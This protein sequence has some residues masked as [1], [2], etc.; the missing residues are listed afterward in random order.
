MRD[1]PTSPIPYADFIVQY[2]MQSVSQKNPDKRAVA[3]TE[4]ALDGDRWFWAD[5]NAKIL[6]FMSLPEVWKKYP[7]EIRKIFDFVDSLCEGPYIFRRTGHPRIEQVSR[8]GGKSHFLHTFL[9]VQSDLAAG[10][11]NVGMR[12]HDGRTAR[13]VIL[14]GNYVRFVYDD[15]A[16]VIDAEDSIST[17]DVSFEAPGLQLKH[18]SLIEF[19]HGGRRLRLGALTYTYSF[20]ARSNFFDVNV[21]LDLEPNISV[22][23][24]ILTVGHDNCSHNENAV[25]YATI[26]GDEQGRTRSIFDAAEPVHEI[27]PVAGLRYWSMAQR[28]EMR[29]FALGVHTAPHHPA[30]LASIEVVVREEQR[31]HYV[32][33]RYHF[34]GPFQGGKIQVEERKALT[35]GGFYSDVVACSDMIRRH[36]AD[37][38]PD[39]QPLD[40]SISYDYGAELA[41]FAR[42]YRALADRELAIQAPGL[43]ERSRAMFD[44]FHAV[45]VENL[46]R[47]H[48]TNSAAIFSR[49]LAFVALGLIDMWK[50]TG[51]EQYRS[52]LRETV[53]ILLE[54]ERL[55]T[56]SGGEV[57]SAFLMGQVTSCL[58][59]I[60]CH[61]AALLALT[62]ALP[63]IGDPSLA[64][65]IQRGLAALEVGTVPYDFG[66][67]KKFETVLVNFP[68]ADGG[69]SPCHTYWNFKAGLTLRSLN[70][71][72]ARRTLEIAEVADQQR[73][74]LSLLKA[75][76]RQQIILSL[77]ERGEALEILTS[78]LSGEGNSETQPWVALGLVADAGDD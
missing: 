62:R 73:D 6:E 34:P 31:L 12:F 57:E 30:N 65:S 44:R 52:A 29:G 23:D 32:V 69:R 33:A 15:K 53:D 3:E 77:R 39:R 42:V 43:R 54:F 25:H 9:H 35:A 1:I 20:D 22:S 24:V 46:L 8:D 26:R 17:W 70:A 72:E 74:R 60:D 49:P 68:T 38:S 11:V 59:Y 13:N 40:L 10:I 2:L 18:L 71:V 16:F 4:N 76:L 21:A 67:R 66:G 58:P 63:V 75:F 61:A 41:A 55:F 27:L 64:A 5:D 47:E 78:Y 51:E 45:Y 56:G 7:D 19:E 28:D 37:R 50:A 36:A 14:T 48:R